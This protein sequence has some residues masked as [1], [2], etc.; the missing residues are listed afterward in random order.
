MP[1]AWGWAKDAHADRK[2]I[3]EIAQADIFR[4]RSLAFA[5]RLCAG[6][7]ASRVPGFESRERRGPTVS[8]SGKLGQDLLAQ[9]LRLGEELLVLGKKPV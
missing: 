9:F 7:L 6:L 3:A 4:Q 8:S 1:E 5:S 2:V